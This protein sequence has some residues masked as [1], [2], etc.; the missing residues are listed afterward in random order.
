MRIAIEAHALSQDKITGVGN[1]V[2]HYMNELQ[3]IDDKNEYFVYTMDDLKHVILHNKK[4]RHVDFQYP[5]KKMRMRTRNRWLELKAEKNGTAMPGSMRLIFYRCAKIILELLDEI[6]FSFK[7]ASSLK[8]FRADVYV[9]TSTYF[10]PYFFF[11]P[12]KKVGMLYDLVWKKY[13]ETMEFGNKLRMRLFTVRNMQK[14]D[15]LVSI[16]VNTKKDASEIL[17][18]ETR[19]E[20]IPLAADRKIFYKAGLPA[21]ASVKKKYRITKPYLLSVCTLEPRKNLKALMEAFAGMRNRDTYQL[22]LAGMTGW[23]ESEFFHGIAGSGI[24]DNVVLTGYIDNSELAPLYTGAEIFVFPSFYEGFGLPVLE[25]MQCGCPVIT[26]NTSSIPEVAG[27]A[28]LMVD[29]HNVDGL[30]AAVE[31]VLKNTT[32]KKQMSEKGLKRAKLF[33]WEKSA[34]TLLHMLETLK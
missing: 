5:L 16:S 9:G 28:A 30:R 1:V 7:L 15:L 32:L 4:W 21:V 17:N 18:I 10:Y 26:S 13:P 33:S 23:I 11:A 29:P 34:A 12:V 27:A 24:K 20:A 2:L 31:Q 3:K 22:V 25:A 14:L 19:I 6:V 8:K